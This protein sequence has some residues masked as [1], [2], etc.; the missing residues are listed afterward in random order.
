[1]ILKVIVPILLVF[2]ITSAQQATDFSKK[3]SNWFGGGLNFS[4]TGI[5]GERVNMLQVTP[6]GFF[7][8]II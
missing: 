1:M 8:Q 5:D 2:S 6:I 7:L 3:G 4:S